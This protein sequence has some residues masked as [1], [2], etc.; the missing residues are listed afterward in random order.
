VVTV[1]HPTTLPVRGLRDA[2]AAA[3]ALAVVSTFGDFV[4]AAIV[5]GHQVVYGLVHGA[6]LLACIGLWLGLPAGRPGAGSL[7]G[8][9]I[10]VV[11]AGGFY[12]LAPL[13]GYAAMFPM[14]MLLWVLFA[15][16]HAR[17]LGERDIRG[18]AWR[19]IVAAAVSGLAFYAIS[20]IWLA[21]SPRGPNYAW[22]FVAWTLAFFPGFAALLATRAPSSGA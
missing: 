15:H 11:S 13:L 10:G 16:L 1:R 22:H 12:L 20:D 4:W 18:A 21:P 5:P 14:W 3:V 2:L 6:V 19:G 8:L 9:A 7:G 17:L